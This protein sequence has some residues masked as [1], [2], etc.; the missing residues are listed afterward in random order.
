MILSGAFDGEETWISKNWVERETTGTP[1]DCVIRRREEEIG[2]ECF[3]QP[4][5]NMEE[6]DR[7]GVRTSRR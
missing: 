1:L 7:L 2:G 4:H 6:R 5:L 3:Q